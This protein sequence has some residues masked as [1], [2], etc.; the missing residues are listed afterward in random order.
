MN[1][2]NEEQQDEVIE[3]FLYSFVTIIFI[4]HSLLS[5]RLEEYIQ[6]VQSEGNLEEITA[7]GESIVNTA[8]DILSENPSDETLD[9]VYVLLESLESAISCSLECGEDSVVIQVGSKQHSRK[10]AISF[11][12]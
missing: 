4:A 1:A 11:F 12:F 3:R 9:E 5:N 8:T 7:L 2:A 10:K 6:V